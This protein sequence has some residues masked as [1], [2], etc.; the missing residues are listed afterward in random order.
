MQLLALL[1]F[2]ILLYIY[3]FES[4]ASHVPADAD[5]IPEFTSAEW[6][7]IGKKMRRAS[8]ATNAAFREYIT[9]RY[10]LAHEKKKVRAVL[11]RIDDNAVY[12]QTVIANDAGYSAR[13]RAD[14]LRALLR[15]RAADEFRA[16][17]QYEKAA[18]KL[19]KAQHNDV[20]LIYIPRGV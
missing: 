6:R 19:N 17:V 7:S 2:A 8:P 18:A 15:L 12:S 14:K 16:A 10:E 3:L 11:Q 9:R 1:I 20:Q 5:E 13:I 4:M